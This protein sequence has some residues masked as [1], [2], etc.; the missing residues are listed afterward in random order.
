MEKEI[1][2]ILKEFIDTK[3]EIVERAL[4]IKAFK[5]KAVSII[6]PRR[7][8]KT[9]FLLY[10]FQKMIEEGK[11]AVFFPLDDDRIF[12]P[13]LK[14]IQ[15][16]IK[17][18]KELYPDGK[19][20]Y[21]F[22]EIQEVKGW[23]LAVKRLVEKEGERVFISGSSSKLLSK[24]IAT[25]L[26]GRTLSYELFPFS[27]KEL[28]HAKNISYGKFMSEREI[29]KIRKSLRKYLF[30][31]GFPEIVLH[32]EEKEKIL[33]EYF[34]T[35][36]YRDLIERYNI[37]NYIGIKLFLKLAINNFSSKFSINKT[38]KYFSNQSI[39][40]SKNTLYDFLEY[41]KDAY[42]LFPIKKFSYSL[43]ET[44]QSIPKM[45]I[46]DN[47]FAHVLSFKI[48]EN[49]GRLLENLVFLELRKKFGQ[50]IYYF[51]SKEGYEVDFL[52]WGNKKELIQVSYV[53]RYDEIDRREIRAL[54]KAAS[55][56]KCKKLTC[57]TWDYEDTK[58]FN[59]ISISFIPAWKWFL[60]LI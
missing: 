24:E 56:L 37:R 57:I 33:D 48:S 2:I 54:K 25:Q 13:S 28:I 40:I 44:E 38:L 4:K 59:N 30:W 45:Y 49:V 1:R 46:I 19:I 23:E 41:A 60:G 51:Q 39:S 47:G 3:R 53:S 17:I 16:M 22:D 42:I 10:H 31:G 32:N 36:I 15:T 27:F 7:A 35:M 58:R 14:T 43:K 29:A 34:N 5:N 6:G 20:T 18:S 12:P 50:N 26:R 9:Y 8:G 52:I 55:L 21:F 11:N